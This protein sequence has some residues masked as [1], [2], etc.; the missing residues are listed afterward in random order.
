MDIAIEYALQVGKLLIH[1]MAG[2]LDALAD[3]KACHDTFVENIVFAADRA[4]A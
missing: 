4:G 3:R 2:N 1:A